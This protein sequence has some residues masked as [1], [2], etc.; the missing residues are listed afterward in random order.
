M[1]TKK[2]FAKIN[3]TLDV[4]GKRDDGYHL[5][6][7][8]M[9]SIDLYDILTFEKIEKGI[10]FSM[11]EDNPVV[12]ADKT[13]LVYRAAEAV[14][15]E[16]ASSRGNAGEDARNDAGES[17]RNDAG[18]SARNDAGENARNGADKNAQ[19]GVDEISPGVRI[20][21][22]KNIPAAAGLAGGSTDAA[23]TLKGVN[24]LLGCGISDERLSEIGASLGADIP[25]CLMGGTALSEGI[26]EILTPLP[27]FPEATFV[28]V[29]PVC[30]V[31]T[32]EV[33]KA[34]DAKDIKDDERPDTDGIIEI[35]KSNASDCRNTSEILRSIAP[36]MKNVLQLVTVPL[37]PEIGK[38]IE[39]LEDAGAVKA[40]MSGSGPTVFAIFDD[41]NKVTEALFAL[42][43][44]K[45]IGEIGTFIVSNAKIEK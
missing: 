22:E 25:Y 28:L 42:E 2:A 7:M 9:Q 44:L 32:G 43:K 31:S 24:E 17:A 36:K 41:S 29:K 10:E 13:N 15:L 1:I 30:S 3:I 35:L 20:V 40:M 39:C 33:Y 12:P 4:L 34:I 38:I 21:L 26:G 11:T 8:L 18:E 14:M 16:A 6:K 19:N 27:E 45:G 5:V 37:H 23:A